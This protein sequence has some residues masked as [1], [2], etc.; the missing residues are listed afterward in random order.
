MAIMLI[1]LIPY[2]LLAAAY[3]FSLRAAFRSHAPG[4]ILFIP[5]LLASMLFTLGLIIWGFMEIE[6]STSSTAA[7]GYLALPYMALIG[8]LISFLLALAIGVVLRFTAERTGW[9]STRLTSV[10]KLIGALL[11]LAMTGWIVQHNVVRSRL[12]D[13]AAAETTAPTDLQSM[14]DTALESDDIELVSRL[15]RNPALTPAKL[16]LLYD[17]GKDSLNDPFSKKYSLFSS[18]ARNLETPP[19]ILADLAFSPFSSVRIEV[20]QNPSTPMETLTGMA[21]DEDELVLSYLSDSPRLPE[22][23][24]QQLKTRKEEAP[25]TE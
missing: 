21:D 8:A 25:V 15:A 4:R 5:S 7:I 9:T 3:I 22:E 13:A 1:I 2:L 23:L 10:P 17:S 24:R 6:A 14:L 18:L 12:L 11:F 16:T 20:I 19:A